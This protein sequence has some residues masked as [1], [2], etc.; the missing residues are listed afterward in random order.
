[1]RMRARAKAEGFLWP[2]IAQDYLLLSEALDSGTSMSMRHRMVG[3]SAL[4]VR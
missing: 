2:A 1:M 3:T 4:A